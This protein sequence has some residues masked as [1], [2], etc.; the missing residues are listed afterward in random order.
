[1]SRKSLRER[2][3]ERCPVCYWCLRQIRSLDEATLDHVVARSKGGSNGPENKVLC[4]WDCN[5]RKA[6]NDWVN[7]D[8]DSKDPA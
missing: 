2:L 1:M 6:N 7:D 3:F 8:P 5:Q 4:C